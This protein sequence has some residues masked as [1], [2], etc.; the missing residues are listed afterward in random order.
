MRHSTAWL[1]N[2]FASQRAGRPA[3]RNAGRKQ[4]RLH[5]QRCLK[6]GLKLLLFLCLGGREGWAEVR[7]LVVLP[8]TNISKNSNIQWLSECLPDL[9]EERLKWASLNVLGRDER[10]IAFDRIG[11]A[12]S[13]HASKATLIKIGQELDAQFLVLGEYNSDGKKIEINLACLEL[14]KNYL[15]EPIKESGALED[16]QLLSGR[17]AWK[18]LTQVD[19]SFPQSLD[20]F[21]ARFPAIPNVALESY[22]RGLMESDQIKQIRFFRQ[23]DR[24][25]PNYAKAILQLGKV[26]YQQKDYATSNL[27][28]Q[29][30]FRS[31]EGYLEAH[32]L[33]GLNY[34]YLKDYD[35]ASEEFQRLSRILPLG[36]VETNLGI[37]LSLK[38][39]NPVAVTAL[40]RAVETEPAEPDYSFNLAYHFWRT[41]NFKA[42]IQ[43]LD[44]AIEFIGEDGEAHYLLYKCLQSSGNN[45]EAIVA[46]EEAKRLS[47]KVENWEARKQIPDLFR[48]QTH[49][50]ETSLK[51]LQLQIQQIK[52][53]K[54]DLR[55]GREKVHDEVEQAKQDLSANRVEQA[56]AILSR[57]IQDSPQSI[58]ARLEMA[59]VL[60]AKGDK[61][62]AILELRASL[63]LKDSAPVRLKLSRLYL[64]VNRKEEARTEALN[65]LNLEP[66]NTEARELVKTLSNR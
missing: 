39:S 9:L 54:S 10:I 18:L 26:Y 3:P 15:S 17:L 41:G 43:A 45:D 25:Y 13:T 31:N 7:T 52:E 5:W 53:G 49:F 32:F 4:G 63:W 58:E 19:H 27:W 62:R 66:D 36:P 61:D 2:L 29:K 14:G 40:Q 6:S 30:L 22:I 34:L 21:L 46:W 44:D 59:K 51:Q 57:A 23:A 48:I 12:Y 60:E 50:D 1:D 37:A 56:E 65:A 8:F 42:A 35:K 38:G 64:S 16:I 47:P 28:L 24:E 55:T 33:V 20:A 11:I